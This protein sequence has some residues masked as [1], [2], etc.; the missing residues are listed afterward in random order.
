MSEPLSPADLNDFLNIIVV[1]CRRSPHLNGR[2]QRAATREG[3]SF[4]AIVLTLYG[5]QLTNSLTGG[6]LQH[7]LLNHSE[8][9]DAELFLYF[10]RASRVLISRQV[11][12]LNAELDPTHARTGHYVHQLLRSDQ[13]VC[14]YNEY[15]RPTW[16]TMHGLRDL[17]QRGTPW[18]GQDLLRIIYEVGGKGGHTPDMV[19]AVLH[20]LANRENFQAVVYVADL[21]A[22]ITRWKKETIERGINASSQIE[23]DTPPGRLMR[24]EAGTKV[25]RETRVRLDNLQ[26]RNRLNGYHG[27]YL[28]AICLLVNDLVV[29]CDREY[30]VTYLQRAIPEL[31]EEDYR[32]NHRAFDDL[33]TFAKRRFVEL[34][35][36]N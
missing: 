7:G 2:I 20:E 15:G 8:L 14:I 34:L 33:A 18:N 31:T 9:S 36:E 11:S 6:Q 4:E 26:D 21:I 25:V 1:V 29:F 22:A 28:Q 19:A 23:K 27:S 10:E 16:V 24:E 13:N 35:A 30:H 3:T 17:R 5:Q 32:K 12:R